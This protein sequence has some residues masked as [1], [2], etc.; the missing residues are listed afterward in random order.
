MTIVNVFEYVYFCIKNAM[1]TEFE[2]MRS[3]QLYDWSDPQV[4]ESLRRSRLACERFNSTGMDHED[5]RAALENLIPGVPESVTILPPFHCDHGHGLRLGD[6][7]FIN[8]NAMLLDT[9]FITIGP[10]TMFGPNVSIYTCNHPLDWRLRRKTVETAL[11]VTIGAD[12]WLGG[13]VVVRPGVTIGDRCVIGA[14]SVVVHDIPS[15][16]LAVG[17]PCRVIR[18]LDSHE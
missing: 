15:D 5:Y 7:V 6:G 17:N 13:N 1:K 18:K 4:D 10:H 16:S 14:G 3:G 11:P 8:Y 2:K 9:A 12:C